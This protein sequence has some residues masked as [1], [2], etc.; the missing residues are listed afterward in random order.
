M[1]EASGMSIEGRPTTLISATE[2][3]PDLDITSCASLRWDAM[4]PKKGL[5]SQAT[6]LFE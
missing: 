4:L 1:A 3:A 2:D 5:T 6:P